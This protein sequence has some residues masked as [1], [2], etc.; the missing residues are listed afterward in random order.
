[1]VECTGLEN[2]HT[3]NGIGSSNLPPSATFLSRAVQ[4]YPLTICFIRYNL[5]AGLTK[6]SHDT[7]KSSQEIEQ[8]EPFLSLLNG[9]HLSYFRSQAAKKRLRICHDQRLH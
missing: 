3:S 1:M 7:L 5:P 9:P 6:I 8:Q 2:R 4:S